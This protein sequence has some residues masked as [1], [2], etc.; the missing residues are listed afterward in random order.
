M[1]LGLPHPEFA[2]MIEAIKRDVVGTRV[3]TV[4]ET[5]VSFSVFRPGEEAPDMAFYDETGNIYVS[6]AVV[7]ADVRSADL[8]AYHEHVEIRHK[9]AGRSHAY[10]HRR[11]YLEELLAAKDLFD[12]PGHFLGYLR[13][14]IGLY[15]E[16]KVLD[17]EM[18]AMQLHGVLSGN[19]PRKGE[20]LH[21]IKE[22]RL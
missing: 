20:L 8:F 11:A 18:V 15:P 6:E 14:R 19:K 5:D 7:D 3:A 10:A 21:V 4:A 13:W 2:G 12:D 9:R 1:L 22:H 17:S 16:W